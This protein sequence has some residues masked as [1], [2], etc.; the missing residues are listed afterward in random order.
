MVR[1]RGGREVCFATV[2]LDQGVSDAVEWRGAVES[3]V[4]GRSGE[5]FV[6]FEGVQGICA[7]EKRGERQDWLIVA[8]SEHQWLRLRMED[9]RRL[10]IAWLPGEAG[11]RAGE[12]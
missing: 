9:M 11:G 8:P 6:G 5:G 7:A 12:C 4:R 1:G 3:G 10:I 2:D